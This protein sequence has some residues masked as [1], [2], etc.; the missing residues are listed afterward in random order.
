MATILKSCI[1]QFS[2]SGFIQFLIDKVLKGLRNGSFRLNNK[3]K[4]YNFL[5]FQLTRKQFGSFV[6][7]LN[8]EAQGK[9]IL[10]FDLLGSEVS[11]SSENEMTVFAN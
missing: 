8:K 5:I 3:Q 1:K 10:S 11:F 9:L 4:K 7:T 2:D 6:F